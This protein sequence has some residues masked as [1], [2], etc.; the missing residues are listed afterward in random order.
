MAVSAAVQIVA[1]GG[2]LLAL[3]KTWYSQYPRSRWH[4]FN[5]WPEWKQLDKIG[6]A[7]GAYIQGKTS[8]ELWKWA[9]ASQKS[10][11]WI[12]GLSGAAFQTL[13]E[14]MDGRSAD[15]GWSWGDIGANLTGTTLLLAQELAWKEQ[16]INL[17]FSFH[18]TSYSDPVLQQRS[19]DLFGDRWTSRMLKDYNAQTYWASF[20]WK[21]FFK[22]SNWPAWLCVSVGTGASGLWGGRSN[23]KTDGNGNVLF[24]RSDI[25]RQRQWFFSPDIDFT[26]IPSR[27][28][29]MRVFLFTLNAFKCPLPTLEFRAG[30]WKIHPLY[31]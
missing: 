27:K 2:T 10:S 30:N 14:Y 31:F 24:D 7:Y 13:I 18:P 23:I 17:K 8:M 4:T 15:W 5:D 16:R 21:S 11:A 19:K 20:R 9:G 29:W 28:K 6:H 22:N 3:D 1:Y 12:G 25:A 26:K